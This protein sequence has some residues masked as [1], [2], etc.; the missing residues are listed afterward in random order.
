MMLK[1]PGYLRRC[2]AQERQFWYLVLREEGHAIRLHTRR[3]LPAEKLT[4][5][6]ELVDMKREGRMR[7]PVPVV[8]GQ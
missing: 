4:M 5:E 3:W 1:E 6:E 2:D 8:E 7:V